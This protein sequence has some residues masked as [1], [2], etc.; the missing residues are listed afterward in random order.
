MKFDIKQLRKDV[1]T[2]RLIDNRI[3]L[4]KLSIQID[5]SIATLSRME[6]GYNKVDIDTLCKVL[7]WL[8]VDSS[9][10]FKR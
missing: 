1:I 5:V 3:T 7:E 10:Y 9:K 6:R 4:R 8:D 2:K